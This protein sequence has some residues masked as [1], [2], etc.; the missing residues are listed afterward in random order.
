MDKIEHLEKLSKLKLSEEERKNFESEFDSII[1]FVN[2]IS[3]LEL[4][5]GLSK[6]EAVSL[7]ALRLDE[8]KPSMPREEVMQNAPKQKDGEYVTPL[9]IE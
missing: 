4:P 5:E 1:D 8:P 9:V 3:S 2:E 7:S 6:D